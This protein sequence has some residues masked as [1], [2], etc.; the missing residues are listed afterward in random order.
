MNRQ[1]KQKKPDFQKQPKGRASVVSNIVV[2]L[3]ND[4]VSEWGDHI[5]KYKKCDVHVKLI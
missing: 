3:L 5:I 2:G 4:T 1:I